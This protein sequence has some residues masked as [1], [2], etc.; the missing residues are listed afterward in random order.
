MKKLFILTAV[1]ALAACQSAQQTTSPDVRTFGMY[2]DVKEVQYS[3]V[4]VDEDSP[5]DVDPWEFGGTVEFTFDQQGRVTLDDRGTEFVYGEDGSFV[6]EWATLVRDEAGRLVCYDNTSD[7]MLD[8][9]EFDVYN[10][11]KMDFTYD[12]KGRPATQ[13]L[14]GWEWSNTFTFSYDGDKV[15]PSAATFEGGYEAFV[16]EGTITYVYKAFD[17]K[18]NWTERE[19]TK[20]TNAYEEPWEDDMEPEVETTTNVERQYRQIRYWSDKE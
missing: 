18:G 16:E 11:F 15:Y 8:S 2:G 14:D 20:V 1:L 6:S 13:E 4:A 5:A 9:E 10:F 7:E 3:V 19:V 17:A 12:A